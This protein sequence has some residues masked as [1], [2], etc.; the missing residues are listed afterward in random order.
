[1]IPLVTSRPRTQVQPSIRRISTPFQCRIERQCAA[2]VRWLLRSIEACGG[3]GSAV[4]YSRC[5]RP[6][7]GWAPPYPETTGY[8]I[9]TLFDAAGFFGEPHYAEVARRQADWIVGLQNPDGSLPGGVVVNGRKAGPSVFN[10]GQMIL[11]LVAAY[12]QTHDE[13]YLETAQRAGR[14]LAELVDP[15]AKIWTAHSYVP[16]YSPAYYTRVCWPML[17]AWA[18]TRDDSIKSAAET[19]LDTILSWQQPN[20]AV[21]NWGF[22]ADAPAFTHTIAYTMRGFLESGRLLGSDGARFERAALAMADPLRRS[23]ELRGRLPGSLDL[24][25]NGRYWFVCLTGNCQ[26]ALNW[27]IL[28]ERVGDLRYLSA[29]LKAYQYVLDRQRQSGLDR[30]TH[31]AIAGSSPVWGRYLTMRYP[32]WAVKFFVDAGLRIHAA[33]DQLLGEEPCESP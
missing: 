3:Q 29:A 10:T 13:K 26:L 14:W 6:R 23:L 8:I 31:G 15:A 16:G 22:T 27:T 21:K 4:Y 28:N 9:E 11:G 2:G 25:L 20:G 19:V 18:R 7:G 32:N 33:M 30:N 12:D 24:D 1:M 5:F 17:E